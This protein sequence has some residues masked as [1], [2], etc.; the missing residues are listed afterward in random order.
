MQNEFSNKLNFLNK[1]YILIIHPQGLN[2]YNGEESIVP[3]V[4]Y[5]HNLPTTHFARFGTWG[6]NKIIYSNPA[7]IIISLASFSMVLKLAL[8]LLNF[9]STILHH[10]VFGHPLLHFP[11]VVHHIAIVATVLSF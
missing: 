1:I 10:V 11:S 2:V 8:S 4:L 7:Y 3:N 6:S 5:V 9:F